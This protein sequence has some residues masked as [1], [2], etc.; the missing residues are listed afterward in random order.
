MSDY[1]LEYIWLTYILFMFDEDEGWEKI[2]IDANFE[3]HTA[4]K[5]LT[6]KLEDIIE[7]KSGENDYEEK[8]GLEFY[9]NILKSV[10]RIYE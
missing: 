7:R 4:I 8:E 6:E 9:S 10:R 3:F 5:I 2:I 1:R